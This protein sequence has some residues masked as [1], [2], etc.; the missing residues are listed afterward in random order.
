MVFGSEQSKQLSVQETVMEQAHKPAALH[1]WETH[2]MSET[3][4][5]AMQ[6]YRSWWWR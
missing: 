2:E 5:N 6:C 4:F 1:N 3:L